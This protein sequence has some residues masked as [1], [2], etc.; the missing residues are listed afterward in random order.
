[1]NEDTKTSEAKLLTVR[2]VADMLQCSERHVY[3]LEEKGLMP[4][5]LRPGGIVRWQSEKISAWIY[6][7]CQPILAV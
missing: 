3:R 5:A 2:E 4:K 6:A 1:M 7:G